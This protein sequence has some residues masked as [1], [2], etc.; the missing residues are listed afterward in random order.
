MNK[1]IVFFLVLIITGSSVGPAL[2]RDPGAPAEP[3][4][5]SAKSLFSFKTDDRE[6]IFGDRF[7]LKAGYKVWV[8][9][10]Q[11]QAAALTT[12]QTQVNS[13]HPAAMSGPT[14]TGLLKLR[15]SEWLSTAF[16]NFTW[17]SDGFD[18][19]EQNVAVNPSHFFANRRDYSLTAG[20]A[21]WEGIGIYGGYYRSRQEFTNVPTD[22]GPATRHPR[23]LDGPIIGLFANAP[24]SERV[25]V[26]GNVAYALLK[27]KGVHE[28]PGFF[29]DTDSAQGW[30]TEFGVTVAGPRIW[31][32]GTEVQLGFRAQIV[33][34]NFGAGATGGSV[35]PP[36][37]T[38]QLPLV[39]LTYGPVFSLSAVF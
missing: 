19:A 28:V 4:T 21:I 10:W 18:F 23:S 25:G 24:V 30:M 12:A 17:L 20:L 33:Q 2:A 31:R 1:R 22:G 32:V 6:S 35:N 13:D 3:E 38:N 14:V 7:T 36:I 5:T 34:K 27:F 15:E 9:K 11:A 37:A 8:A 39:D 16:V 29:A 26:Y